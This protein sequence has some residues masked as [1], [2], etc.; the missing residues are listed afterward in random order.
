M[1]QDMLNVLESY[2]LGWMSLDDCYEWLAGISWD[3]PNVTDDPQFKDALGR[4]ELL[5]T[6]AVEGLRPTSEFEQLAVQLVTS[7]SDICI[8]FIGEVPEFATYVGS[9]DGTASQQVSL[10]TM[11]SSPVFVFELEEDSQDIG[12]TEMAGVATVGAE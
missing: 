3:D 2:L 4:M 11:D 8:G 12:I 10:P 9:K 1:Y 5:A 6:E 7:G